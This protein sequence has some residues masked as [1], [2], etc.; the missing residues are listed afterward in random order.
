MK[1]IDVYEQYFEGAAEVNGRPRHA[2]QVKLTAESD[3]GMIRYEVSVNFFPHD[4]PEDFAI[5]YVGFY[6]RE[7]YNAKG[8]RSKKKEAVWLKSLQEEADALAAENGGSIDWEKPLIE[9]RR[10]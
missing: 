9:A 5:S 4:D 10:G 6:A 1:V 7:I 2:A 3:A 8:R